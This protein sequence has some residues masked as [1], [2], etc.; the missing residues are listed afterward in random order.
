MRWK[1]IEES[2]AKW[3][4]ALEQF[5]DD[6]ERKIAYENWRKEVNYL[7]SAPDD[8]PTEGNTV[9]EE[10]DAEWETESAEEPQ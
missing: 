2:I 3:D 6:E 9:E 1:K 5:S 4:K 7:W 8:P 10:S